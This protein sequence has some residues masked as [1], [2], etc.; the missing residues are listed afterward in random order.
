M[1]LVH[2]LLN[3]EWFHVL[4]ASFG[5]IIHDP[6]AAPSAKYRG[7]EHGRQAG[8]TPRWGMVLYGIGIACGLLGIVLNFSGL[9]PVG[10]WLIGVAITVMVSTALRLGHLKVW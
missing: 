7:I 8:R 4:A 3:S 1:K 2:R 5:W 10:T 9:L 6:C